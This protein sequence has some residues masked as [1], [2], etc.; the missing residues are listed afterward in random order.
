MKTRSIRELLVILKDNEEL[1]YQEECSGLCTLV[2]ALT[3]EEIITEDEHELISNYIMDN[4]PKRGKHLDKSNWR[5]NFNKAPL[6]SWYW[7]A[8]LWE[9]REAWLDSRLKLKKHSNREPGTFES[10]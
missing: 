8:F 6:G 1:F 3:D 2:C 9:P 4:R 5:G 7:E 10:L